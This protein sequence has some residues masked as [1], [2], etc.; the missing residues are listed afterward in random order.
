M[1]TKSPMQC[2]QDGIP[3]TERHWHG[4]AITK[5]D[6]LGFPSAPTGGTV[7]VAGLRGTLL[8]ALHP[9]ALRLRESHGR[10]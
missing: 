2:D 9:K 7:G 1:L 5:V 10:C 8:A 4:A 6:G 3:F